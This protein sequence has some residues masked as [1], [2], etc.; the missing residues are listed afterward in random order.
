MTEAV[1]EKPKQEEKRAVV[2][3]PQRMQLAEQ[4]RQDWVVLAEPG[5][6]IEDITEPA[7]WA[8]MAGR[9]QQ[10][11][12]IEVRAET[13]EWLVELIVVSA[14]R[15]WAQLHIAHKFDLNERTKAAPRAAAHTVEWKGPQR[16]F[17]VIR[18]SDGA[19][20]QEGFGSKPE[21]Q[22]WLEN[23]ERVTS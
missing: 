13:G 3:D 23:H 20:L 9:L 22:V 10:F 19:V 21:A 6:R 11:D 16:K 15:N 5:T 1:A 18:T 12:R 14:G 2:L 17:S 4:W 7:Y 8:H